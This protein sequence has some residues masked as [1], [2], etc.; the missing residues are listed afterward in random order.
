MERRGE[1]CSDSLGVHPVQARFTSVP[2]RILIA[3]SKP[4]LPSS[5]SLQHGVHLG[6]YMGASRS[7][8]QI[9]T[10]QPSPAMLSAS[11]CCKEGR[12]QA[13]SPTFSS[14]VRAK[15]SPNDRSFIK[16]LFMC[17]QCFRVHVLPFPDFFFHLFLL[18]GGAV[19]PREIF[20][21]RMA[22]YLPLV[23]RT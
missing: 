15:L 21:M 12:L 5:P 13:T 17:Y 11:L 19:L 18:K 6:S 8:P 20:D 9:G 10:A 2:L 22:S 14:R 3:C 1:S 7:S 4:L 16:S 23:P